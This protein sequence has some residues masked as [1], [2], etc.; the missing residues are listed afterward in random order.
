M[1][2]R[3]K[4]RSIDASNLTMHEIEDLLA[5]L[6]KLR[7]ALTAVI[8]AWERA[9]DPSAESTRRHSPL[10]RGRAQTRQPGTR[11]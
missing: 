1:S 8:E 4:V 11:I 6:Y 2:P 5:R 10:P 3:C 7:T 9:F